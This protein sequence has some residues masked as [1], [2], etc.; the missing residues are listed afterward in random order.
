[1]IKSPVDEP[2][3]VYS[4]EPKIPGVSQQT[5]YTPRSR[6]GLTVLVGTGG[7][8]QTVHQSGH[9]GYKTTQ[10]DDFDSVSAQDRQKYGNRGDQPGYLITPGQIG[11]KFNSTILT[12]V[13]NFYLIFVGGD[14]KPG[15]TSDGRYGGQGRPDEI[16]GGKIGTP[17]IKNSKFYYVYKLPAIF[18]FG[19]VQ[20]C[21]L[22]KVHLTNIGRFSHTYLTLNLKNSKIMWITIFLNESFYVFFFLHFAIT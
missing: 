8:V 18:C 9:H 1:M 10:T 19:Y 16:S 3:R 2:F 4:S 5:V 7:P 22:W 11:I 20:E 13:W 6:D 21:E 14:Y 12:H 15:E 17:G